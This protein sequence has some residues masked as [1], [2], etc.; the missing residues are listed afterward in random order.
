MIAQQPDVT[1][2]Y[3]GGICWIIGSD[4]AECVQVERLLRIDAGRRVIDEA[5]HRVLLGRLLLL[6]A[7]VVGEQR[8]AIGADAL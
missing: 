2:A 8:V 3:H 4:P 5:G 6:G 1:A 7:R